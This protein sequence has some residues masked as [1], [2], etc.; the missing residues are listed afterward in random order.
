MGR[1]GA[2]YEPRDEQME[3][4]VCRIVGH[5]LNAD[6]NP[7]E[8]PVLILGNGKSQIVVLNLSTYENLVALA[9]QNAGKTAVNQARID[10]K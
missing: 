2:R 9:L 10:A 5:W 7:E 8:N 4:E 6:E 3:N 1:Q